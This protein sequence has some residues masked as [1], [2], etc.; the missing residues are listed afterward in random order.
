MPTAKYEAIYRAIK[1]DIETGIYKNGD[2]LPS[3]NTYTERFGCTRNTIRRALSV[4]TSEGY[5]LPQHGRGVQVIYSPQANKS[6]FTGEDWIVTPTTDKG[7]GLHA[8]HQRHG[9]GF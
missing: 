7:G 3:E 8:E 9:P 4:L 6:L 2:F 1:R 5:L